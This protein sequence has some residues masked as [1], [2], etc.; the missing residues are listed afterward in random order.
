MEEEALLPVVKA[1]VRDMH[2]FGGV[3]HKPTWRDLLVVSMAQAPYQFI[4]LLYMECQ[5]L[6]SSMAETGIV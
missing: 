6:C 5:I 2:R 1:L 3:F 4:N